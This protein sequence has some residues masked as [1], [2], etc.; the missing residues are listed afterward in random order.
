MRPAPNPSRV[1]PTKISR[2]EVALYIINH[3]T[4]MGPF[5]TSM[6]VFRPS[7]SIHEKKTAYFFLFVKNAAIKK[8]NYHFY[9]FIFKLIQGYLNSAHKPV[10]NAL[11]TLPIGSVIII[12]SNISVI[13]ISN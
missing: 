5:T 9:V 2:T 3:A 4:I 1:L 13:H 12:D 11:I 7:A 10:I 8:S 6:A